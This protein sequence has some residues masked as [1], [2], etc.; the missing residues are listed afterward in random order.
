MPK[1]SGLTK[2]MKLSPELSAI[3]GKKEASRAECV[4]QLLHQ[5]AQPAGPREQAVLLARRHHG[6]GLRQGQDEGV[7]H[8]QVHHQLRAGNSNSNSINCQQVK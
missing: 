5:E 1:G 4:K 2:A 8:V 6:Q 3:V 7:H